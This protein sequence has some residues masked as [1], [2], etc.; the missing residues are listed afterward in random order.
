[1]VLAKEMNDSSKK[2]KNV[3]VIQLQHYNIIYID[4]EGWSAGVLSMNC[5]LDHMTLILE[6]KVFYY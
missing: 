6:T 2:K 5:L 1:M 4:G 3:R